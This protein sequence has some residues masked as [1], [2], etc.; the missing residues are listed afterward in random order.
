MHILGWP[1]VNV[2]FQI[3][4]KAGYHWS[5]SKTP[6][7]LR[8]LADRCWLSNI[9]CWV[10]SF[11]IFLGIR[12]N[13]AKELY[14][15]VIF[16]GGGPDLSPLWMR[17]CLCSGVSS[18]YEQVYLLKLP[19]QNRISLFAIKMNEKPNSENRPCLN[20]VRIF[21]LNSAMKLQLVRKIKSKNNDITCF[22]IP[23]G[24]IYP[25]S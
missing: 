8:L 23:R 16:Q 15:F 7:K 21:M 14:S 24:C 5:T 20:V 4:L 12:T 13:I 17:A 22:L 19:F 1:S 18:T 2:T 6:F 25:A 3:P 11:V 9:E 10:G